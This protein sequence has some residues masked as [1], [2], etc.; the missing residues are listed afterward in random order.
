M[1]L[2]LHLVKQSKVDI[3][4]VA[5]APILDDFLKHLKVLAELDLH[6][7][8]DFVVMSST[9]MEIKSRELLP[10]ESVEIEE[11]FDPRDDLIRR[12]LEY[13]QGSTVQQN[14]RLQ[15][16]PIVLLPMRVSQQASNTSSAWRS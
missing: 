1:D 14:E 12:L 4:E 5:I 3:H 6:D 13:K 7:I 11:E 15:I 2:L 9:L 16:C 8:G 10:N